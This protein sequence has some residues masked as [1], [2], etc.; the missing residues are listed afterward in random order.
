MKKIFFFLATVLTLVPH[1]RS[2]N[3]LS[4]APITTLVVQDTIHYYFNKYY[5]K[6]ATP[7]D[8]F[9]YYKSPAATVTV[10]THMGSY[11]ENNDTLDIKGLQAYASRNPGAL[12]IVPVHLYLCAVNPTT[13]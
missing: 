12:P 2:Q 9:P 6:T 7:L 8:S 13:G 10:I 1:V 5:F 11:F 3:R 4:T